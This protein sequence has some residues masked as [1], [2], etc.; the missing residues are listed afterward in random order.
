MI[1]ARGWARCEGF[2][3]SDTA[4][5]AGPSPVGSWRHRRRIIHC[6]LVYCGAFAA[7]MTWRYPDS[8]VVGQAVL[9]AF[10]LATLT[11][12]CYVFGATWDDANARRM[13]VKP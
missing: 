10:S 13:G 7:F 4:K 12:G 9:G 6:V 1:A 8:V 3:V 2:L 11:V 5:T